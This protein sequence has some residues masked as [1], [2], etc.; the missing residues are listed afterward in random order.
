[1]STEMN[2][3]YDFMNVDVPADELPVAR[4]VLEDAISAEVEQSHR[5]DMPTGPRRRNRRK[6]RQLARWTAGLAVAAAAIAVLIL[7]VVPTSTVPT[8]EAAA[9]EISRLADTVQPA[10]PLLAGQWYQYELQGVLSADVSTVGSTPTPNAQASLPIS[11]GQWS[12]STGAICTSQRFGT[13]TFASPVNAQA[14]QAIGL[15]DTPGNQPVTGCSAGVEATMGGGSSLVTIDVSNIT[16]DPTILAAQLQDGTTG[17]QPIDEHAAQDPA[18][19]AGFVR[20]TALL[21]GPTSGQW[22][23]FG[24]E[25]LETMALLPGVISLGDMTSHSGTAG[26]GF[27]VATRVTLNPSTGAVS[28]SPLSHRPQS[29]SIHRAEHCSRPTTSTSRCSSQR[30]KTSWAALPRPCTPRASATGSPPNG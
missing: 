3:V 2:L 10:P 27:S 17:I 11:V 4:A 5:S 6:S 8:S 19:V 30:L 22:S 15:I 13:A 21:V 16:H 23:G 1:M 14:G 29:S 26:V 25:M 28:S 20:L 24:Q 12:N 7:E 9:A 18:N